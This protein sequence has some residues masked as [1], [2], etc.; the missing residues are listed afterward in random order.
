MCG[1]S[2]HVAAAHLWFIPSN[3]CAK[4]RAYAS[5]S[6]EAE[7]NYTNSKFLEIFASKSEVRLA[8]DRVI[9]IVGKTKPLTIDIKGHKCELTF[10]VLDHKEYDILLGLDF[11]MMTDAGIYPKKRILKFPNEEIKISKVCEIDD[12]EENHLYI[13]KDEISEE[14]KTDLVEWVCNKVEFEPILKIPEN[15]YE[16]FQNF[17]PKEQ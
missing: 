12:W 9:K 5:E 1:K 15:F 7:S 17:K 6:I 13:L 3:H 10:S 14:L 4:S 2:A 16:K 11:F 8:D